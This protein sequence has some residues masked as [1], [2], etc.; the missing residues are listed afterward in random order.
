MP[1]YYPSA[2]VK[3]RVR[4]DE[5][6]A[7]T[8]LR[9]PEDWR[10]R[11]TGR[12]PVAP[13]LRYTPLGRDPVSG[14]SREGYLLEPMTTPELRATIAEGSSSDDGL[15]WQIGSILPARCTVERN[16]IRSAD[17]F[18]VALPWTDFPFDP[19]LV[20][21]I[22]VELYVGVVTPDDFRRGIDGER[23]ASGE[24]YSL[25][26][27]Y[28]DDLGGRSNRRIIGFV[29]GLQGEHVGDQLATVVLEGR[30]LTGLLIDAPLPAGVSADLDQSLSE[31][32]AQVL[33]T[34]PAAQGLTVRVLPEGTTTPRGDDSAI[35]MHY[36]RRRGREIR[37]PAKG[38]QA[39]VSYWDYLTD[40]AGFAGF[41]CYVD[42]TDV[43][44]QTPRSLY[45][46]RFPVRAGDA[47]TPRTVDGEYLPVRRMVWGRNVEK[48]GYK[49]KYARIKVNTV[50]V[51]C[52][53]PETGVTRFGRFPLNARVTEAP[54]GQEGGDEKIDVF[55]V[56]GIRD[57]AV[58]QRMAQSVYEQ[59]GR[60]E[61]GFDLTT[62]D[63][64][65]YDA[66]DGYNT[67]FPDLLDARAGDSV[68]VRVIRQPDLEQPDG[69][70]DSATRF[71][72]MDESGRRGYL[73]QLGFSREL[74]AKYSEL[75]E[76][77]GHQ[78]VFRTRT[79]GIEFDKDSGVSLKFELM[80][81]IEVREE[82]LLPAGE[83][84][85]PL[86]TTDP[87]QRPT[88]SA[89][90]PDRVRRES[91]GIDDGAELFPDLGLDLEDPRR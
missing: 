87:S 39:K 75:Y 78:S 59:Q 50:E 28:A 44:I 77:A 11:T 2:K 88:D 62:K 91:P 69:W 58:L 34:L 74:S 1:S 22:G 47:F 5:L 6:G 57:E 15:T 68:E 10:S 83:E 17:T 33:S 32:F 55:R 7:S 52:Y 90:L 13:V 3:L 37:R 48:L 21:A 26:P 30:D 60:G 25:V 81:Y 40:L 46:S 45:G 56:S 31:M 86:A 82:T 16:G 27:D 70:Q 76:A 85:Q 64:H 8:S 49:R 42:G 24:P 43:V 51:R 41:V 61:L 14:T 29:D 89:E 35:P 12:D 9:L 63:L 80:N 38:K 18:S 54:P 71:E 84:P 65:S 53:D 67:N 20:R 36:R 73:E 72:G 23:R 66:E 4:F 19:R 79:L